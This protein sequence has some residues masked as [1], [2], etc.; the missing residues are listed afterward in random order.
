MQTSR[1]D[2]TAA[3]HVTSVMSVAVAYCSSFANMS[4]QFSSVQD[5]IFAL[6]KAR[7]RSTPSLRSFPKRCLSNGSNVRL[8]DDGPLSS[9]QGRSSS[10]SSL[11]ASSPPGDRWCLRVVSQASQHFKSSGEASEGCFA[12]QFGHF[13][14]LR[15]VQGNT[16]N[17][18][19]HIKVKRRLSYHKQSM[20]NLCLD[21]GHNMFEDY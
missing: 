4:V 12:N 14:S 10:A 5:G 21:K 13:P 2:T 16:P 19:G 18:E 7:T 11:H 9:F 17:R 3:G 6:G 8:T 20:I 1:Q 15:H